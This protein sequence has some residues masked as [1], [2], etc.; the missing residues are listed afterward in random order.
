MGYAVDE[1][2]AVLKKQGIASAMIDGSGDIGVSDAPPGAKGWRIGIATRDSPK[3]PPS[4]FVSLVN[5]AVTT[6]GDAFQYVEIA[7][8]HYSHIVDPQTGLGLT[9]RSSVTIVAA[10]CI[11][12]DSLATAVSVLGPKAGLELV[13][14][15]SGVAA[16]IMLAAR[17]GQTELHTSQRLK[18]YLA[19][20][21]STSD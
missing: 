7:G 13:E 1:A 4:H 20:P 14:T 18:D 10:D 16:L 12:A 2:L 5:A 19:P 21:K 9:Q 3:G 8:Q 17:D 15:T 6:S 11:T